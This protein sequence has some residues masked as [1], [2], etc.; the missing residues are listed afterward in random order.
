MLAPLLSIEDLAVAFRTEDG[1]SRTEDGEVTPVRG[2]SLSVGAN[3]G[4]SPIR[5]FGWGASVI[6]MICFATSAYLLMRRL[7]DPEP[8]DED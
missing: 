4:L 1:A 5:M 2:V 3:E 7:G 6:G 8:Q